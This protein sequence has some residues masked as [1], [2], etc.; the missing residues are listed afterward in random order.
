VHFGLLFTRR[1]RIVDDGY[2]PVPVVPEIKNHV[3][4]DWIS[5][6][7]H[8]ANFVNIVPPDCLN[9]TGP[10]FDFVRRIWVAFDRFAQVLTRND[11]HPSSVLHN[12]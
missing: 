5:I 1:L 10:R 7:E 3:P 9:D 8:S 6:V 12:L 11:V 2:K 4:I